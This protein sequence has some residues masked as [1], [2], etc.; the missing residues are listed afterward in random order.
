MA[1]EKAAG[2]AGKAGG[3][4][5][6]GWV[7]TAV[8][9]GGLGAAVPYFLPSNLQPVQGHAAEVEKVAAE[10]ASPAAVIKPAFIP[11]GEVVVNLDDGRLNRYLDVTITLQVSEHEKDDITA[12]MKENEAV[13]KNWLISYLSD[14]DMED[15]RGAIGQNRLRREIRD[16]FNTLLFPDGHDR[17]NQILFEKFAVQ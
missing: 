6:L 16:Q 4:G 14:Q 11:F 7:I 8:V 12:K 5:K 3:G 13:L 10:P 15:I 2:D 17:I 9:A 1:D